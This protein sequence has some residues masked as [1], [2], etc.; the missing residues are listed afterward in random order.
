MCAMG[1]NP[2]KRAG[3]IRA[4]MLTLRKC[5]DMVTVRL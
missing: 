4:K 3:K 5:S 2:V 1:V